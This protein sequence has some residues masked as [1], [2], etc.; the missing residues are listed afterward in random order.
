MQNTEF[1][2]KLYG[3]ITII[4]HALFNT[5]IYFIAYIKNKENKKI[6]KDIIINALLTI[7][8]I[9]WIIRIN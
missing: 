5:I 9:I 2:I 7:I 6:F 3:G 1:N 8:Y 4:L